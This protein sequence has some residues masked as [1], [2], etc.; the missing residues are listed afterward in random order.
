M[1]NWNRALPKGGIAK[2]M[3]DEADKVK[4]KENCRMEYMTTMELTLAP[5]IA[6]C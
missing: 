5:K 4:S 1:G 2:E 6:S 3:P